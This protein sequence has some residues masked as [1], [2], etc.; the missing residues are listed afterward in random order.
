MTVLSKKPPARKI[1]VFIC[2]E[3]WTRAWLCR[4]LGNNRRPGELRVIKGKR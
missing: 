2:D 4:L 1:E 3:R